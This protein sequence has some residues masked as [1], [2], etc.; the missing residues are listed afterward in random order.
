VLELS[1][2]KDIVVTVNADMATTTDP[3]KLST[4][5]NINNMASSLEGLTEIKTTEQSTVKEDKDFFQQ[6]LSGKLK[7]YNADEEVFL[8][9]ITSIL[10]EADTGSTQSDDV[11]ES[12]SDI[13]EGLGLNE[14]ENND[15]ISSQFGK[16]IWAKWNAAVNLENTSNNTNNNHNKQ[17]GVNDKVDIQTQL[18]RITESK[19]EAYRASTKA[20]AERHEKD[21]EERKAV[22]AAILAQ[23]GNVDDEASESS[24]EE[25][26]GKEDE[27][28]LMRN[29][30]KEAV[31]KAEQEKREKCRAAALAKKEKDKEDRE[32]QKNDQEER[33]KKA[34]EKA[35][36]GERK[37]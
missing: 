12:L 35:S 25:N 2:D 19:S 23:Y 24:D 28:S 18:A 8:P 31:A 11:L 33:K 14:G 1:C 26:G 20:A 27:L 7:Y 22:K 29:E 3:E 30:N 6:W 34:Q 21:Q 32:K 37:R 17:N 36:K 5:Q 16:E 15:E 9:Y 4:T 10:E 13:L